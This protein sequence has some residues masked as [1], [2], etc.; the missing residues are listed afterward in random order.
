MRQDHISK[1]SALATEFGQCEAVCFS[2]DTEVKQ[3]D[4]V[5]V[6]PWREGL[7]RYF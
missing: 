3:Y 4:N 5:L 2:Q 1:L 6:L 7:A